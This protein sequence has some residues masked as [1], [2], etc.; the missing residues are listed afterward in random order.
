MARIIAKSAVPDIAAAIDR[1]TIFRRGYLNVEEA[2]R[3]QGWS[4]VYDK[5]G[6]NETY[7][8]SF[9]FKVKD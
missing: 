5:P 7:D 4:V 1:E 9:E 3:E 6:Y 8:A 2:Y